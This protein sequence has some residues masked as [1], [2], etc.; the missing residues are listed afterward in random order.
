[1]TLGHDRDGLLVASA[2]LVRLGLCD[3]RAERRRHGG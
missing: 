1:M 3:H 2:V